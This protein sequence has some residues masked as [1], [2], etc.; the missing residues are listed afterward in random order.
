VRAWRRFI[1]DAYGRFLI[2][3]V[4]DDQVN[5]AWGIDVLVTI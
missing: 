3:E 4:S 5:E 2:G 1:K